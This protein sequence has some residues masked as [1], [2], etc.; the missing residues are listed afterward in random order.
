MHNDWV[1]ILSGGEGTRLGPLVQEWLGASIPKQYC[2]FFGNCSLLEQTFLRALALTTR[3]QVVTVAGHG[4]SRHLRSQ[5]IHLEGSVFLEQ[6]AALGTFVG[7]LMGAAYVDSVNPGATILILP[8]DHFV[9]PETLFREHAARLLTVAR[10][11]KRY[12]VLMAVPSSRVESEYGWIRPGKSVAARGAGKSVFRIE[13][14]HEKPGPVVAKTYL[15]EGFFWNT[16]ITAV[17]LPTLWRITREYSPELFAS[18]RLV[19]DV[20]N[21]MGRGRAGE[22]RLEPAIAR[23]YQAAGEVDFSRH[24][25]QK[26]PKQTLALVASGFI[27]S[28]WGRA[29]RIT[30]SLAQ[31]GCR[32]LFEGEPTSPHAAA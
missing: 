10:R 16:M 22:Q 1:V 9:H 32:P 25:L 15:R 17:W 14:F 29:E 21:A 6:P 5:G 26:M 13:R 31:I 23:A 11:L 28:D 2:R 20:L 18:F 12:M 19:R 27:W 8:S 24:L 7:I 4:H 3:E 30:E